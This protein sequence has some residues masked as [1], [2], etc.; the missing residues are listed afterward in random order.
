MRAAAA[1]QPTT[2]PPD[3]PTRPTWR[4]ARGGRVGRVPAG[5]AAVRARHRGGPRSRRLPARVAVDRS[6]VGGVVFGCGW[7]R[8]ACRGVWLR[9]LPG[10][11]S[12][13]A[14]GVVGWRPIASR[15]RSVRAAPRRGWGFG[16][17]PRTATA[18]AVGSG[19]V[20]SAGGSSGRVCLRGRGGVGGCVLV[21]T[22]AERQTQPPPAGGAGMP[23]RVP[24][25]GSFC[26]VRACG[27]V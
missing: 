21:S 3:R 12:A 17:S 16:M 11:G 20:V 25:F 26:H 10:D 19:R 8:P 27:L 4:A 6:G 7:P 13:L 2:P 18:W 1:P 15:W 5:E 24:R 22:R 14:L 9:A 23:W